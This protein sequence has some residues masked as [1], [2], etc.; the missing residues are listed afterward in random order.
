LFSLDNKGAVGDGLTAQYFDDTHY[1]SADGAQDVSL[2]ST[3]IVG[4]ERFQAEAGDPAGSIVRLEH[5]IAVQNL[6]RLHTS[7]SHDR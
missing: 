1:V 7:G 4:P 6:R 3:V 5:D 2:A